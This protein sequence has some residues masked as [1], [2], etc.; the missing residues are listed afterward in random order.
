MTYA[1]ARLYLGISGVGLFV[2]LAFVG[3]WLDLPGRFLDEGLAAL[4]L[5]IAVYLLVHLPLD[6]LGG[7]LL[8]QRFLRR[9]GGKF[10]GP[11]LRGAL[12]HGGW[13][14]LC[15]L[16]IL[17]VGRWGGIG[18][19][20]V[21]Q[22]IVMLLMVAVQQ[23]IARLVGG[24]G[25]ADVGFTGGIAGL[26]GQERLVLPENWPDNVR[27]VASMRREA[28]I[29]SGSRTRGL[30]VAIAWNLSGFGLA[31]LPAGAGVTTVSEL[32]RTLLGFTL[33]SFLGLLILPTV[34]R[35]G[36]LEVDQ[37]ARRLGLDA[38]DFANAVRALD[39]LQDDEPE[40][41]AGVEAIFHPIPQVRTR[42]AA[43]E[44][45]PAE[46]AGLGAWNAARY[47]LYLSWPGVSLL[48][49]AV[50]CNAGRPELWVFPPVE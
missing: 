15:A 12:F 7:Y 43:F 42:L 47:A 10:W 4:A 20:L 41:P 35:R 48:S 31:A 11:Y 32:A 49:R 3:L 1:R 28:A 22:L 23:Q 21:W 50:H 24:R 5:M 17:E 39:R 36:V 29:S 8:P 38:T 19:V 6:Y 16:A 40:R 34:S 46:T 30:L 37:A 27:R 45:N 44:A 26:P 9:S 2:L 25:G 13:L 33:W 18:A 14:L